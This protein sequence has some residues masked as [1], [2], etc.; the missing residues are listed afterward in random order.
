[1]KMFSDVGSNSN[2]DS[3]FTTKHTLNIL[4]KNLGGRLAPPEI[5]A[6]L[7]LFWCVTQAFGPNLTLSLQTPQISLFYIHSVKSHTS[8]MK[9]LPI[10][11]LRDILQH[12]SCCIKKNSTMLTTHQLAGLA[13]HIYTGFACQIKLMACLTLNWPISLHANSCQ[14]HYLDTLRLR[15]LC[16]CVWGGGGGGGAPHAPL[17]C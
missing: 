10:Q 7:S 5:R 16:V 1:M 6:D 17:P 9:R 4:V 3:I 14:S 12:I 8:K 13:S 11:L 2:K 15:G